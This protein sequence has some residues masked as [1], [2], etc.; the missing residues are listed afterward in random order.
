MYQKFKTKYENCYFWDT[1]QLL[2]EHPDFMRFKAKPNSSR[3]GTGTGSSRS[4]NF[5][6]LSA[7]PSSIN[8]GRDSNHSCKTVFAILKRLNVEKN[9]CHRAMYEFQKE[10]LREFFVLLESDDERRDFLNINFST[11][12][13][14]IQLYFSWI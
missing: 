3:S 6:D 8:F 13:P 4:R 2:M 5:I 14:L 9:L 11:G 10:D 1:F 12:G 7:G